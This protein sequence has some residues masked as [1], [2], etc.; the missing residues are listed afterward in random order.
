MSSDAQKEMMATRPDLTAKTSRALLSASQLEQM[1]YRLGSSLQAGIP[2]AEAWGN[3]SELL[4]GRIHRS[5]GGVHA[6]LLEGESL[7]DAL[8]GEPCVPPMLAEMVRAGEETGQLDQAFLRMADYYRAL[9]RMKRTFWQGVTWPALQLVA[10][11]ALITVF[12]VALHVLQSR[13]PGLVAPDVFLLGLSPLENLLLFWGV[14]LFVV[15]SVFLAVKGIRSGWFGSLPLRAA[16]AVPLLGST[17]KSLALSRF[18]WAFGTA[19]DAGMNAQQAILL[20][21]RSTQNGL[22]QSHERA[23]AASVGAGK[24]FFTALRRTN[25]F[26][27]DLLQAVRTGELTGKLTESLARLAD[28][29]RE[30]SA[31]NLRRISQVSG[32]GVLV[33]TTALMGFSILFMYANYLGTLSDALQGH[34]V[35]LEQIRAGQQTTNPIIATRDN[36]VKDFV[37]NNEDFKQIESIYKYLGRY[38][39]MTPD[40]FLDGLFP[41]SQPSPAERGQTEDKARAER[42]QSSRGNTP[43]A[44]SGKDGS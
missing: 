8:V 34:A 25:A 13:I 4:R 38:N 10:A 31:A 37:E 14:L 16:L 28:D 15:S 40:E 39:E 36:M 17:I 2:I 22:Y 27:S 23:V 35:T 11:A 3:E 21:L 33:A 42:E 24:D 5:F 41:E 26:P 12:F 32:F 30:Q 43:G 18:A 20:G 7:A 6:R 1:C 19:A 29:Y 44:N 9:V